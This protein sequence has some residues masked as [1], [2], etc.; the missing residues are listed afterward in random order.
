MEVSPVEE[1]LPNLKQKKCASPM[2]FLA[3]LAFFN[4]NGKPNKVNNTTAL[5]YKSLTMKSQSAT[6]HASTVASVK[7]VAAFADVDTMAPIANLMQTNL[8]LSSNKPPV[9]MQVS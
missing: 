2:A 6:E 7:M 1:V 9:V 8:N 4:S 3:M 5:M